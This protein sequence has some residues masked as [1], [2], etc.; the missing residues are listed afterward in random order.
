MKKRG[1]VGFAGR[2][3]DRTLLGVGLAA[4]AYWFLAGQDAT[5]KFLA[6]SVPVWQILF[7][8][9]CI[10]VAAILLLGRRDL[11]VRVA[12]T[13]NKLALTVRGLV[14]LSAWL[15]YF[16]AAK[17][18][19]LA[20]LVTLYFVAPVIVTILAGPLL[21]ER[22]SAACWAAVALGFAGTVAATSPGHLMVSTATAL[23]LAAALLWACGVILTR[24]IAARE[25]SVLQMFYSNCVFLAVTGVMS[26][27]SW[28]PL[29]LT[30]GLLI[31]LVG[32]LG[33][34]GQFTMFEA[35]RRAPASLTAPIEYSALV[36]AFL[37]GY[38]IWGDIPQANV[39][40]GAALISLGGIWLVLGD[41]LRPVARA[42]RR[43]RPH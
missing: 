3:V 32:A 4:G 22:V 42:F 8:R 12:G 5:I 30:Q 38:L 26:A 23:V 34:I 18:L 14:A 27:V 9:S 20:Q 39:F 35:A 36:W 10:V 16:T 11:L 24:R 37:L 28:R 29:S 33:G 40:V 41:R 13:P 6:A 1:L 7:I 21:G 15:C 2:R 17:S 25:T 43:L 19:P 31:L